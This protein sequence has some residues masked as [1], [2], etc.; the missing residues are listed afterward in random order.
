M[1]GRYAAAKDVASLVEEFEVVRPPDENLPAD[2]NVAPSKPV[3]M[4]VDRET[5]DGVQRQL[6]IA[7]WGLIPSWAKDPKIGNRMINA[8]IETAAEKPAFRRAWAK[9]R[10]LLP[11]DGYYEWY[12]GQGVPKQPFYIHRSDGASL[13]MAGLFEFWKDGEDWLVSTAILT[14]SAPDAL[15]Q[16]HDRMPL[17]VPRENWAKWLDP[18]GPPADDIVVPAMATGLEAYPVSTEVNNVKHNGP[19]LLEPLPAS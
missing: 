7:K 2:Y 17:L 3:Y 5:D 10:C 14:T 1:C 16:I 15:G 13:A 6:R 11:A 4:V 18:Q 9:R 12:A 19:Q 8:R